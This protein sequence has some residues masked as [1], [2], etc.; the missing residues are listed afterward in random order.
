MSPNRFRRLVCLAGLVLLVAWQLVLFRQAWPERYEFK[1]ASGMAQQDKFLYFLYYTNLFPIAST[2]NGLNY[3]FYYTKAAVAQQPNTLEYSASGAESTLRNQGK[4]LVMEWGHTVRSGQLLSTYLFLPDAWRLGSPE[5]AE[6]RM[7]HGALFIASLAAVYLASCW[8]SRPVFGAVFV[9]LVGSNP[10]Q[11]YEAYRHENVFS[12]PITALC[13]MLALAL[14]L[15]VKPRISMVYAAGAAVAAGA[16]AA[17]LA[18]IRPEPITLLGGVAFAFLSATSLTLRVRLGLLALLFVTVALGARAWNTYFDRKFEQAAG[19]VAASGG[20]VLSGHRDHYHVFWHPIWCGLGDFGQDHGYSWSD[21]AALAYAQPILRTRYGQELP[22]W[23]GV[24]GKE[25]HDRTAGDFADAARTYYRI[26]YNTPHYDE[27]MRDKV[28]GD[29]RQD[30]MW[31]AGVLGRRAWRV[32][33]ETTRPQVTLSTEVN[34]PLPFSGLLVAPFA[35][36]AGLFRRW[37]DLKILLFSCAGS[38]PALL[39]FSGR[40]MTH[41]SVFH[42]C[43]LAL[44]VSWVVEAGRRL[45]AKA[46]VPGE[47]VPA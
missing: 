34:L 28:L 15:L 27:V 3:Y 39:V 13:F 30:P 29:I 37:T 19:V 4:T 20:R 33:T 12:W 25:E 32:L 23:W 43:A 45:T 35:L 17:T 41:Y 6:V 21:S 18:Q 38:L 22:W 10:F 31:Y 42:L 8:V 2:N 1:A 16:L 14:P 40:G 26:P 24:Q 47:P 46:E 44:L 5:H 36:A 7:T 11:L 9:L